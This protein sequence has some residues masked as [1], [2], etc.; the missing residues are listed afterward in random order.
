MIELL[1]KGWKPPTIGPVEAERVRNHKHV[2]NERMRRERQK[3]SFEELHKMLPHGTKGDKNSIVQMAAERIR[4]LQR[5][6]E[7][8]RRREIELELALA[9]A[10]HDDGE[11]LE[12]A[13]IKLRV[14]HPSSGINSLLEV[15]K[16]LRN[17]GTETRAI[18]SNFSS[19]EFSAVLEI[20]AK[21][22]LQLCVWKTFVP[23]YYLTRMFLLSNSTC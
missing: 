9:A 13:K 1:R 10:N 16:C 6:K 18:Q 11:T 19:Q 12:E 5:C 4:E 20:E 21:V 2:M 22:C 14:V 17:T 7:E 3:R 23:R 8:L 15:L